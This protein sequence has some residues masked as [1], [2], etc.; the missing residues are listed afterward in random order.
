[1]ASRITLVN[2]LFDQLN[3][4]LGQLT[5]MYP[6]DSDFP[7]FAT[8]LKMLKTSNPMMVVKYLKESITPFEQ[9]ILEKDEKFFLDY[10]YSEFQETVD[11]NIFSKLKDYVKNMEEHNKNI[12]WK[13]IQNV[14]RL[15]KTI[16]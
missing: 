4:F 1:M 12:V 16:H 14:L 5:S 10:S 2:A 11:I 15:C 8:T 7:M 6:E 9:Q 13:Y 3:S